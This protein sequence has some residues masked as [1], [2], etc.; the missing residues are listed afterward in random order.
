M[1]NKFTSHGRLK[2]KLIE[3]L[4]CNPKT[5]VYVVFDHKDAIGGISIHLVHKD[6]IFP[7]EEMGLE[8][9]KLFQGKVWELKRACFIF[10]QI[11]EVNKHETVFRVS[12]SGFEAAEI[13]LK[14]KTIEAA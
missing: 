14:L 3:I 4:Q 8:L 5:E 1:T 10:D 9:E 7:T 11:E 12:N 6:P 2:T 13:T